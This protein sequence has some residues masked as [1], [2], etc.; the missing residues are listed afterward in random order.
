MEVSFLMSNIEYK[1]KLVKKIKENEI[2]GKED[3]PPA[4]LLLLHKEFVGIRERERKATFK[5]RCCLKRFWY[6]CRETTQFMCLTTGRN[7]NVLSLWVV[8]ELRSTTSEA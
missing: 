1:Y 8:E 4:R 3:S 6:L 7:N 5:A 2:G